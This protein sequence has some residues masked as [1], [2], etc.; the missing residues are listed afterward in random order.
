MFKGGR[1]VG[2]EA[3][4]SAHLDAQDAVQKLAY[5]VGLCGVYVG[6]RGETIT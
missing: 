3:V 6:K 4:L 2:E 1:E 5:V